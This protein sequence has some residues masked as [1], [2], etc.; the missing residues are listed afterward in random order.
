LPAYACY[1]LVSAAV[2]ANA[3]IVFYDVEPNTLSPDA[4]SLVE[5]CALR[6]D[7][8]VVAPL[9]GIP[10]D[11]D[12]VLHIVEPTGALL[13]EDAAQGVGATWKGRP[14]GS[15]GHVSV[16][17]FGRGKGWTGGVGGAVMVHNTS[18]SLS[19][20]DGPPQ[21]G[22]TVALRAVAQWSLSRPGIYGLP[23][24]IPWLRL[25]ETDYHP[26][27][28][29][30]PLPGLAAAL[31]LAHDE[32]AQREAE[33]R[34]RNAAALLDRLAATVWADRFELI[35][36]PQGSEP[37]FLR[38][39]L[40]TRV[41]LP[42]LVASKGSRSSGIMPGYPLRLPDLPAARPRLLRDLPTSGANDLAQRLI[43]LPTHRLVTQEDV[44]KVMAVL[45]S[46][47]PERPI[48]SSLP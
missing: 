10:V 14:L 36:P 19:E 35:N 7:A 15:L 37:A 34:R 5:A 45:N 32:E 48:R 30:K 21:P 24:S 25:G 28:E 29:P 17:S 31:V 27:D 39:P 47:G 8:V 44:A 42:G 6:P 12:T 20:I 2:G 23:A 46:Y 9:Y 26:P 33:V 38:L 40:L 3:R 4:G 16:L 22:I 11:W 41:G 18:A 43:T 13:I 1:D